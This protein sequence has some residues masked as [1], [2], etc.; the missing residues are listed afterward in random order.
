[1]RVR[2]YDYCMGSLVDPDPGPEVEEEEED[3]EMSPDA[4]EIL[5]SQYASHFTASAPPMPVT[6][7]PEVPSATPTQFERAAYADH[8]PA[9]HVSVHPSGG[10]SWEIVTHADG[11]VFLVGPHETAQIDPALVDDLLNLRISPPDALEMAAQASFSPPL[12]TAAD[13][14][15]Y[16]GYNGALAAALALTDS[17]HAGP[18]GLTAAEKEAVAAGARSSDVTDGAEVP[19]SARDKGKSKASTLYGGRYLDEHGGVEP[20]E[21]QSYDETELPDYS[22]LVLISDEEMELE[23]DD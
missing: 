23:Q 11:T 20:G 4:E 5:T 12:E 6:P 22:E 9:G 21:F 8:V 17:S 10:D 2:V 14:E 1:M 18:S 13:G 19:S 7:A 15:T 3:R 16:D